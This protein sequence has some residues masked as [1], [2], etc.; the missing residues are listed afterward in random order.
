LDR[1]NDIKKINENINY[2]SDKNHLNIENLNFKYHSESKGLNEVNLDAK[3]NEIVGIIGESGSGKSTLIN[4][5]LGLMKPLSGNIR[6]NELDIHKNLNNWKDI[7]GYIPQNIYL[8]DDTI[9]RNIGFG[10]EDNKIDNKKIEKC[11]ELAELSSF[12]K[13]LPQ[14]LNTVVGERGIKIS[15]GELQ[16]IGI[17]RA[18]YK[19]PKILILDEAT[20]A[21]D[22]DTEK[23][24]LET[25][26]S[27][28]S[29]K[30]I[31][32][33][34]HRNSIFDFCKKIYEIKNG[35]VRQK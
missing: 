32:I 11:I 12:I 5:M 6:M 28:K 13:N 27:L 3:E 16:R 1:K 29:N 14:G 10:I 17:A 9:L 2:S 20:S 34:S 33:V 8:T 25:I 23:N 4:L 26:S 21:L 19:D 15:G 31:I 30:I 35:Y 24:I 7:I 18:L 22:V